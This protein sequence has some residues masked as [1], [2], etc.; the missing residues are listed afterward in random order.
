[1]IFGGQSSNNANFL[2]EVSKSDL[3]VIGSKF[4]PQWLEF[5]LPLAVAWEA[6]TAPELK[7]RWMDS[8]KSV[9]VDSPEARIGA[10]SEYHCAHE[11]AD[12][13]YRVTDWEPFEYFSTRLDDSQREGIS[14]PETYHLIQTKAGTELRYTLGQA[15]DAD[16]NRSEISEQEAAGFLHLGGWYQQVDVAANTGP[17]VRIGGQH[18]RAAFEEQ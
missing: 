7:Q 14:R 5:D 13:R 17:A 9:S 11:A 8:M 2:A 3:Q 4:K 6:L 16:G 12:F 15:H 10:G 1:M 18:E